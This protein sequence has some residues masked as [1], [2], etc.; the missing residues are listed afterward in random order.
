M[1]TPPSKAERDHMLNRAL[2][3]LNL[4]IEETI[5]V[6]KHRLSEDLGISIDL[7]GIVVNKKEIDIY[8]ACQMIS[9]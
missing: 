7:V 6:I 8:T 3:R 4:S 2:E 1:E 9:V 5:D